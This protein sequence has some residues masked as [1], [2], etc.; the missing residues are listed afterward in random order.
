MRDTR[1]I[2]EIGASLVD[3][4][5]F[6]ASAQRDSVLLDQVGV[7]LDRALMPL[8]IR[9]GMQGPLGV[10]ALAG[11]VG[12]DHTTVSRQLAK[13]ESLE[14][15]WRPGTKVDARVRQAALTPQGEVIVKAI[16]SAR[17]HLLSVV[18][19]NWSE[20]D[21]AALGHLN[22]RFVEDLTKTAGAR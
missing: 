16:V 8:L 20:D 2:D 7:K 3:L 14:L 17:R 19:A 22:R 4:M 13:L 12:R 5:S 10:A 15:V 1:D 18:L 21:R 9:L 11:E 6:F